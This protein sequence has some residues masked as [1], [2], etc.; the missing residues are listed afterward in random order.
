[1]PRPAISS[2]GLI[3]LCSVPGILVCPGCEEVRAK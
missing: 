3:P 2:G 1:V